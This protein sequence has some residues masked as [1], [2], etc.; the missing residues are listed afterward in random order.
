M[1]AHE[2]AKELLKLEDLP[3]TS[4]DGGDPPDPCE[5]DRILIIDRDSHHCIDLK[6]RHANPNLRCY[7]LV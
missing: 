6:D 1:T 4:Y 2:L 5:I 3:V 7:L